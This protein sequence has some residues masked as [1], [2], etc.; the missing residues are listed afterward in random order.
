MTQAANDS[1]LEQQAEHEQV[2]AETIALLEQMVDVMGDERVSLADFV[3]ILDT[4]LS[5]FGKNR[6]VGEFVGSRLSS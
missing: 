3:Q 5:E 4:G 2:W 6:G 1:D